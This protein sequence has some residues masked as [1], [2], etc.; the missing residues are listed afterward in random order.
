MI[1]KDSLTHTVSIAQRSSN[2]KK[3]FTSLETFTIG[4]P[5]RRFSTATGNDATFGSHPFDALKPRNVKPALK[6]T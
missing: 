4:L 1:D 2:T 5:S 6:N 3:T